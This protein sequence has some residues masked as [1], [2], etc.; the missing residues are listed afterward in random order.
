MHLIIATLFFV[1]V[2]IAFFEERLKESNKLLILAGY[3]IFMIYLATTKSIEH[4]ADALAYERYF[5]KND[6]PLIEI[7][8]EPTFIYMSRIIIAFG[9]T[10]VTLFFI[11][12]VLSIPAKIFLFYK[13]TPYIFT[14][15]LIYIPVYFEVQDLIQIRV[16]AAAMFLL[17]SLFPLS[18]RQ[19]LIAFL[20]IVCGILFHYSAVAYLPL[21]FIGNMKLNKTWRI[22][23]A[24][25]VPMFF[26]LY[27]MKKDLFFLIPSSLTAGKIDYYQ[28]S[29]QKGEWEELAPLYKNFFF[30]AKCGLLYV[31][32]YYYDIIVR[33]NK[34]APLIINLFIASILFLLGMSTIPV[35]ASRVSDLYGIIDCIVFTYAFYIFRPKYIVKIGIAIVG[36]YMLVYNML[37]TEYFT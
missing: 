22:I 2:F 27:L 10:L 20:L 12:A 34:M 32:L 6:N 33:R 5:Y 11:Y 1:T 36:F 26:L 9:G 4:T 18:R 21:L 35:L 28:E 16:S 3:A 24:V 19:H 30:L 8:T 17:A 37:F 31:L 25:L 15:L 13:M 7:M 29:S 23:V 14:A